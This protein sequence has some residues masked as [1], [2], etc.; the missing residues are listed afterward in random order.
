MA[1][2]QEIVLVTGVT[3]GIGAQILAQLLARPNTKVIAGVRDLDAAAAKKLI[4]QSQS[5]H[6]H[7]LIVVKIDSE[8]ETDAADAA[9]SLQQQHGLDHVDVVIANA[10]IAADWLPVK[11]VRSED[12]MRSARVNIAAPILLFQAFYP[13][14]TK[15]A[16]PRILFVSTGA[17][18]FG[19]A[20]LIGFNNTTYGSSKAALNYVVV[21][22]AKEH[23]EITALTL[24]PGTVDTD[25]AAAA[26]EAIGAD[27]AERVAKGEAISPETSAQGIVKLAD[28]ARRESHSGKFFDAV[29]GSEL[30]W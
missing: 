30:P 23:P 13:L 26:H 10:G 28:D 5:T 17:A 24:H 15:S 29:S 19:L 16:N 1:A 21:R 7:N 8:S 12:V 4:E 2:S 22:I 20:H 3:R 18:S 11:E 25:M 14:L 6:S 27:L 9:Q